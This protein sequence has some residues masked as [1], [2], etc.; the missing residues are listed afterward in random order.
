[1][2]LAMFPDH[3]TPR[4]AVAP[5][6]SSRLRARD[7]H[8]RATAPYWKRGLNRFRCSI[9][10]RWGQVDITWSTEVNTRTG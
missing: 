5:G 3:W 7:D 9:R 4:G 2:S 8:S 6:R 1:M 10:S